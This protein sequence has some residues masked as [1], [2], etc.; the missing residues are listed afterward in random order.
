[1]SPRFV[2][3]TTSRRDHV[4]MRVAGFKETLNA[5]ETASILR[6]HGYV[7]ELVGVEGETSP[8]RIGDLPEAVSDARWAKA[9]VLSNCDSEYF[10]EVVISHRGQVV[11]QHRPGRFHRL[12]EERRRRR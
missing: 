12:E 6:D 10:R 7:A 4:Y 2:S 11:W 3:I 5:K 1:M 9:F 8:S